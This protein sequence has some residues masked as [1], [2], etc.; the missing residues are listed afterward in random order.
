[1]QTV[2]GCSGIMGHD[3]H[4]WQRRIYANLL[5]EYTNIDNFFIFTFYCE[6]ALQKGTVVGPSSVYY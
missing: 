4:S 5:I 6:Q 2:A 3:M 1:M